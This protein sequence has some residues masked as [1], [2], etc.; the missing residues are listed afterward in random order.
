[1]KIK[2]F[3]IYCTLALSPSVIKRAVKVSLI[4]G[5][6]LNVINQEEVFATLSFET[7]NLSKLLLTYLVPYSVTTYTAIA[8]KVEF[9]IGTKSPINADL[10]CQ[11]C[12]KEM[13]IQK[14]MLIPECS[15]CGI[16]TKWR[17]L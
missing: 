7:L 9:Q 10:K 3:K 8:M 15:S 17:L 13:Y 6:L 14:N 5:T 1:M 12:G 16:T 4:V 2:H 11:K